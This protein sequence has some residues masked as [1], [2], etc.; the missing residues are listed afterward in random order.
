MPRS[1]SDCAPMGRTRTATSAWRLALLWQGTLIDMVT[2]RRGGA[3]LRL[4]TGDTLRVRL[5]DDA[6]ELRSRTAGTTRVSAGG[7]VELASGETVAAAVV[8]ADPGVADLV[9][10][11]A[12]WLHAAMVGATLQA[13]IVAALV[14]T[15]VPGLDTEHGGG[16]SSSWRQ[17]RTTFGGTAPARGRAVFHAAGRPRAEAE[18]VE[19]L[20]R[21]GETD[22]IEAHVRPTSH[23]R[24][25]GPA[26]S[27]IVV[28]GQAEPHETLGDAVRA[29]A[30]APALGAGVGGVSPMSA[31][32]EGAGSGAVGPGLTRDRAPTDARVHVGDVA[33]PARAFPRAV[34]GRPELLELHASDTVGQVDLPAE[35]RAHLTREMRRQ[36]SAVRSCYESRG[37]AADARLSGRLVVRFTLLPDGRIEDPV[38]VDESGG[39]EAVGAC[40]ERRARDWYLGAGLVAEP[41]PLA[42]PFVL[43]PHQ[44]GQ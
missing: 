41:Q 30:L 11:D 43:R 33:Q 12:L 20:H 17:L 29:M 40:I 27:E 5:V 19:P 3:S 36:H 24:R 32:V 15:P 28:T 39:L 10:V 38:V 2:L 14:L 35:V 7:L 44:R 25:Q 22:A 37:L 34:R 16:M 1:L 8:D 23:Q 6:V 4:R 18:R 13:C 26:P 21:S 9:A 42:F 31:L